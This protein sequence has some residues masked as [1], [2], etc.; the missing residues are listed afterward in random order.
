MAD[1]GN[2]NGKYVM[3]PRPRAMEKAF[4]ALRERKSKEPKENSQLQGKKPSRSKRKE[5]RAQHRFSCKGENETRKETESWNGARHDR[6]IKTY[7][8]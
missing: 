6:V 1:E 4:Q 8:L 5:T 2:V 3:V 7:S